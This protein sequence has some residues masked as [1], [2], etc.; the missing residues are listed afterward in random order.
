MSGSSVFV[1]KSMDRTTGLLAITSEERFYMS[2]GVAFVAS[3][4]NATL[5]AAADMDM[6]FRVASGYLAVVAPR[7]G[8]IAEAR[9]R[10]Y[11][12]PTTSADG[13][14]LA[15]INKNRA[16]TETANCAAFSGPTVSD[17]GTLLSDDL[18]SVAGAMPQGS[19]ILD[20]GDYL[21]RATNLNAG[22]QPVGI[23]MHWFE[24]SA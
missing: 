23:A 11:D 3:L 24:I 2:K 10:V 14:A 20:A 7:L 15:E 17:A 19:F 8:G 4:V 12:G 6:L 21:V 16:S 9:L 22:A 18:A 5:G 13:A 1:K